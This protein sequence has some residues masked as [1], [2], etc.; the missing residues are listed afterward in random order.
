MSL[1]NRSNVSGRGTLKW[2]SLRPAQTSYLKQV[3]P[4]LYWWGCFST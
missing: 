4:A 2:L 3:V 1:S